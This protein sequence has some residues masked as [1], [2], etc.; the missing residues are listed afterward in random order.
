MACAYGRVM[1]TTNRGSGMGPR[2][3][4][5]GGQLRIAWTS[6]VSGTGVSHERTSSMNRQQS[7]DNLSET[8]TWSTIANGARAESRGVAIAG[9]GVELLI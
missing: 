7:G 8:G 5:C 6:A 2:I 9:Q 4:R 3:S 1:W